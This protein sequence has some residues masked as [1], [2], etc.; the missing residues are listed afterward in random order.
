[1][2][3]GSFTD[4]VGLEKFERLIEQARAGLSK[5]VQEAELDVLCRELE[6]IPSQFARLK[7]LCG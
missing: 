7:L 5:G 6:S 2:Q 4:S 3:R 1:M